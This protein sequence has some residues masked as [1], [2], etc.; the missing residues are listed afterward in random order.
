MF[1]I[2]SLFISTLGFKKAFFL[3]IFVFIDIKG[4]LSGAS[5]TDSICQCRRCRRLQFDPWGR[6]DP[7]E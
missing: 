3:N 4:F 1:V 6:E 7:L 2:S 5:G